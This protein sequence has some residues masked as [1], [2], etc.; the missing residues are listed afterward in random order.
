M[1]DP[2]FTNGKTHHRLANESSLAKSARLFTLNSAEAT[3]GTT[4]VIRIYERHNGRPRLK[5]RI[6]WDV[7][8]E[9]GDIDQVI[10]TMPSVLEALPEKIDLIVAKDLGKGAVFQQLVDRLLDK[11]PSAKW[12]VSAKRWPPKWLDTVNK[13][14]DLQ[15]YLIPQVAAQL[16]LN[17]PHTIV[18]SWLTSSGVPSR[19]GL[20]FLMR[21]YP[22]SNVVVLPQGS[23]V[24]AYDGC[25]LGYVQDA[26]LPSD[27]AG[28]TQMASVFLP[29][30]VAYQLGERR[31][32]FGEALRN[33]LTYTEK[34]RQ[35]DERRFGVGGPHYQ[36]KRHILLD[37]THAQ[38]VH[39]ARWR[40][41][42]WEGVIG[43][44]DSAFKNLGIVDHGGR[45]EFHLW[46]GMTELQ[47]YVACLPEKRKYIQQL[48]RDGRRFKNRPQLERKHLAYVVL[49]K[50]GS[51]KSFLIDRLAESLGMT[52]LKFNL[53][54]LTGL[55]DLL[56]CFD[57]IR[58]EQERHKHDTLML[59]FDELN[60]KAAES[61]YYYGGFLEPMDDGSYV[62]QGV[63]HKLQPCFW[64]FA[65]TDS[66]QK[67]G[68]SNKWQDFESR[69]AQAPMN[70]GGRSGG[71]EELTK[72]ER[73]YMGV[74]AIRSVFQDV[75]QVS[76][77]V[78]WIF[79]KLLDDKGPRDI[80]RIVRNFE[81][82]QYGRV[83]LEQVNEDIL[84]SIK[85]DASE[86]EAK[87][88]GPSG[89]VNIIDEP[90]DWWST[91]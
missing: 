89:F 57:K 9:Q 85:A 30:L 41:F 84:A 70:L 73:V 37:K 64:V 36:T 78:L 1:L 88:R 66:P 87:R 62:H 83:G 86:V 40:A 60:A 50:P 81:N 23:R 58:S 56:S 3:V 4:Q 77:D 27:A 14:R 19:E 91:E 11:Y 26:L 2:S 63:A 59:F 44:W 12:Y 24:L 33:A 10:A 29:A 38:E 74:A 82:V 46:R 22:N 39:D 67:S 45:K 16:A 68:G 47:G 61:I 42:N 5:Q 79:R 31:S 25:T 54:Q 28:L 48:L 15:V 72:V 8:L 20:E 52:P 65:G 76:E 51:G 90:K 75:S 53:T 34:W 49:D 13:R 80:T 55:Q 32:D 21:A 18:D 69:L 7:P 35:D 71:A 17:D 6:D 43:D